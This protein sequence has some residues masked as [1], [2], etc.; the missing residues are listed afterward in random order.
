MPALITTSPYRC[1]VIGASAGGLDAICALCKKL[2]KPFPLPIVIVMHLPRGAGD[3]LSE[4]IANHCH[5]DHGLC[6]PGTN[7][8]PDTIYLAPANYHLLIERNGQLNL[9]IDELV[10]FSRPS[11][12]VLFESAA[13]A[14]ENKLIGLLL[15]GANSDGAGG[16]K[17]IQNYG[18]ATFVQSPSEAESPE[19]PQAALDLITPDRT[20]SL[21]ELAQAINKLLI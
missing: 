14:F 2:I 10:H 1:L 6:T 12:D 19:M 13:Q 11:I 21:E 3:Y 17:S 7:I 16:L 18:G 8:T 5:L 4:Y 15:T 20:G 9:N